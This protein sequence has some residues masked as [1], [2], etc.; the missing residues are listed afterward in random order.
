M[1]R[2]GHIVYP[3]K[4]ID[5]WIVLHCGIEKGA[6]TAI[7]SGVQGRRICGF[8]ILR[9]CLEILWWG[10]LCNWKIFGVKLFDSLY[11]LSRKTF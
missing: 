4:Y 10:G 8:H 6:N 9:E 5:Y 3:Q 2:R 11:V 1:R 7:L